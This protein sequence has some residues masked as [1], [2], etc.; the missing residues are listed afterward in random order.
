MFTKYF[1]IRSI[2]HCEIVAGILTPHDVMVLSMSMKVCA[3]SSLGMF[4]IFCFCATVHFVLTAFSLAK[5]SFCFLFA[6]FA[7]LWARFTIC[8]ASSFDHL[9]VDANPMPPFAIILTQNPLSTAET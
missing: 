2:E 1:V 7:Y 3:F 8:L 9:F 5:V 6:C 4:S